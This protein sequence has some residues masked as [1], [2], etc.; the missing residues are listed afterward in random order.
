[1][2][3]PWAQGD[4]ENCGPTCK[5]RGTAATSGE[6]ENGSGQVRPESSRSAWPHPRECASLRWADAL[7]QTKNGR[8]EARPR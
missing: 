7:G 4:F 8:E 1:M 6:L 5:R 2:G 3:R